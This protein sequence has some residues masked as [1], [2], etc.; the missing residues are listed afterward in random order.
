[1]MFDE[2]NS[3][4]VRVS[5]AVVGVIAGAVC[6]VLA[7]AFE[8]GILAFRFFSIGHLG[9]HFGDPIAILA[10]IGAAIGGIV[11]LSV[12]PLFASPSLASRA[13]AR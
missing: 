3:V 1:M 10:L 4:L 13:R 12:R 7:A 9:G 5:D 2:E 11:G 6:A 8:A